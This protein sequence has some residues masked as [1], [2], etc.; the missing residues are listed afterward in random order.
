MAESFGFD[1]ERYDRTRPRYPQ[2]MVDAIVASIPGQD[3][4]DVGVGTAVSAR[5]FREAGCRVVGIDVDKRMADFAQRDE[6]DVEIAKFEDWDPL[7]RTFDAVIS[8]QTWHWIDPVAGAAKAAGVLR[9]H[10]RLAAFWNIFQPPRDL[11]TAIA[12]VYQRLLPDTPFSGGISGGMNAYAPQFLR[13]AEGI[14]SASG[15]GEPDQWEF[16]WERPYTRD[17]W[18]DV[19]PTFGGHNHFPPGVL[20]EV[21][22]GIGAAIDAVGGSFTMEYTAVAVTALRSVN[23]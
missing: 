20:G 15:L 16:P 22:A 13:A 4:L 6:F 11:A 3:V 19:V 17:E 9:P 14:R 10:G 5:P 12:E 8:G 2:A 23:P 7:G 1:A 18:L 21:L